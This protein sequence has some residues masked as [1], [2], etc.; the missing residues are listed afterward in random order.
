MQAIHLLVD[1]T[2]LSILGWWV[3]PHLL[4]DDMEDDDAGELGSSSGLGACIDIPITLLGMFLPYC[5]RIVRWDSHHH[6]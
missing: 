6:F 2:E 3:G 5:N 4:M 1:C